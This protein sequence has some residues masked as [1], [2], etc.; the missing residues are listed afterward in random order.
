MLAG[1]KT[2]IFNGLGIVF[3]VLRLYDPTFIAPSVED[4]DAFLAALDT[5]VTGVIIAGNVVLRFFTKSSVFKRE[6][7]C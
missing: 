3:Y 4:I 7:K 1:Y 5:V 6:I 2:I